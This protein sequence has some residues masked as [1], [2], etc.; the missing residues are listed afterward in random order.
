MVSDTNMWV[1]VGK[2]QFHKAERKRAG[3]ARSYRPR[4]RGP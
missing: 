4:H 2:S 1:N 3:A